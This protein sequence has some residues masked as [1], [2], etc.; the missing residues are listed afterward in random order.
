MENL[1]DMTAFTSALSLALTN[2]YAPGVVSL[3]DL[4]EVS[5]ARLEYE[6]QDTTV[7]ALTLTYQGEEPD[8]DEEDP[9]EVVAQWA[10]DYLEDKYGV[11]ASG[12]T[13]D[14]TPEED[15]VN[16]VVTVDLSRGFTV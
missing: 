8:A 16:Y 3:D 2:G 7:Y 5:I 9:S 11:E 1:I 14:A 10:L 15:W 13:V 6:E 4:W 12:Y